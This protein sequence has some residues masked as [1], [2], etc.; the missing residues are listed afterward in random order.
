ML[1]LAETTTAAIPVLVAVLSVNEFSMRRE[2]IFFLLLFFLFS[3][4]QPIFSAA[5]LLFW[6]PLFLPLLCS[7]LL[8]LLPAFALHNKNNN[9][10]NQ[11]RTSVKGRVEVGWAMMD[12]GCWL[13]DGS[14]LW[15]PSG[16]NHRRRLI[17]FACVDFSSSPICPWKTRTPLQSFIHLV[18][19]NAEIQQHYL[20]T[21]KW[22]PNDGFILMAQLCKY[23]GTFG[24]VVIYY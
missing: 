4:T 21:H 15:P 1:Q 14:Y 8:R 7:F 6:A 2:F 24:F 22:M 3:A 12:A 17:Y 9:N 19:H 16:S 11:G 5:F 18:M 23:P 10:N 13:L 20:H